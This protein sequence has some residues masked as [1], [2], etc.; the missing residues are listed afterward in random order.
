[1]LWLRNSVLATNHYAF[2]NYCDAT[3][4]FFNLGLISSDG[5]AGWLSSWPC[6]DTGLD[7]V[8]ISSADG[9]DRGQSMEIDLVHLPRSRRCIFIFPDVQVNLR[10]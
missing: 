9:H 4:V 2:T 7:A 1:V 5:L 10:Q 3:Q 8:T 6:T